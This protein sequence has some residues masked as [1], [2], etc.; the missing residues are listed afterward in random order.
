MRNTKLTVLAG[1]L[2]CALL[3][4]PATRAD[5]LVNFQL[6]TSAL[7]GNAAGPFAINFQLIDG[8]GAANNTATLTNFNFGAGGSP[9][10]PPPTLPP[11]YEGGASGSLAT[12][13]V[14]TD[15]AFFNEF[16]QGFT[17]G[18]LLSF[19]LL[20]T[21]N[22]AAGGIPDQFSFAL[23]DSSGFEVPTLGPGSEFL[24][25]NIDSPLPDVAPFP[26]DPS[27]P[28]PGNPTAPGVAIGLP[29]VTVTQVEVIPEPGTAALLAAGLLPALGIVRRRRRRS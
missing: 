24:S 18:S 29:G 14:L 4:A 7:V 28:L 15:S 12:T 6:N 17:P 27:T 11:S 16:V 1:L 26:S 19:D 23:L 13:V 20:L 5:I 25:I 2:A 22:V 10:G 8:D 9:G 21:T 3:A